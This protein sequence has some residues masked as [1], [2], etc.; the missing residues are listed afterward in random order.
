MSN[1][2]QLLFAETI[3]KGSAGLLLILIPGLTI[4][5]LGLPQAASRFWPRMLGALLIGLALAS[6]AEGSLQAKSGLGLAGSIIINLSGIAVL[7]ALLILGRT[8]ATTRRGRLVLWS[9]V[10][11]LI[12]LTLL[13]FAYVN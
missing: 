8:S 11:A 7:G 10:L 5:A 4:K 9:L 13:E 12:F 2:N 3:L 6:L 1:I